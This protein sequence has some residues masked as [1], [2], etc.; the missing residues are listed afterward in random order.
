MKK[1]L[2]LIISI[3][4]VTVMSVSLF[5]ACGKP[6][7]G[8][9]KFIKS[10]P[11]TSQ[12]VKFVDLENAPTVSATVSV[13]Y[14]NSTKNAI[15]FKDETDPSAIKYSLYSV[16][17]KAVVVAPAVEVITYDTNSMLWKVA[18]T[19]KT[20]GQ[21]FKYVDC[22]GTTV[23]AD[24]LASK[25]TVNSDFSVKFAMNVVVKHNGNSFAILDNKLI[26]T[27][28][29]GL[30]EMFVEDS[31][32]ATIF[33]GKDTILKF[34]NFNISVFKTSDFSFV[35]TVSVE[36]LNNSSVNDATRYYML[37]NGNALIQVLET[38]PKD[39]KE[40]DIFAD[41][42]KY[43]MTTYIC[44]LT[45]GNDELK[46]VK[47]DYLIDDAVKNEQTLKENYNSKFSNY[48]YALKIA[49]GK[50]A[51]SPVIVAFD[52]NMKIKFVGDSALLAGNSKIQQIADNKYMIEYDSK[53]VI[54][55]GDGV[56]ENTFNQK[57]YDKLIPGVGF[58]ASANKST[59]FKGT[60]IFSLNANEMYNGRFGSNFF[61]ETE[62]VV[63]EESIYS[64][65]V[66]QNNVRTL[67]ADFDQMYRS[68]GVYVTTN[69]TTNISKLINGFTGAE[70]KSTTAD[71]IDFTLFGNANYLI[72]IDGKLSLLMPL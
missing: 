62:T 4:L 9:E 19:N 17:N 32:N 49:D 60:E 3:L 23:I 36:N 52:D 64:M 31:K 48:T 37:N 22:V 70:I 53:T 29:A 15:V 68:H 18:T 27:I 65:Y 63:A 28:N 13:E 57:L 41:T 24:T 11:L 72:E 45:S 33:F 30:N 56:V 39:A 44:D 66:C 2:I 46:E 16:A 61:V 7:N 51:Q 6:T 43:N 50:M 12:E 54:V 35:K 20:G 42:V 67:I 69:T 25:V 1:R 47:F 5:A 14:N 8:F 38:L 21:H 71:N 58:Q 59:D 26:K 34:N 40:F 10:T 55:N